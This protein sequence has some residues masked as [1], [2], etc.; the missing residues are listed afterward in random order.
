MQ[1]TRSIAL[2][3]KTNEVN[4]ISDLKLT[5]EVVFGVSSQG[6]RGTGICKLTTL[7]AS[8]M[9]KKNKFAAPCKRASVAIFKTKGDKL[10]FQF[11]RASMCKKA[12]KAHFKSGYFSILEDF[13]LPLFIQDKLN[14]YGKVILKGTYPAIETKE[15]FLVFF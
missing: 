2:Q 9:E 11:D 14:A 8:D 1:F 13:E 7:S 5:A 6:C 12:V 3:N 10:C 15:S 4:F